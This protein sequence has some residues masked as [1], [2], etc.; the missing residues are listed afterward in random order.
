MVSRGRHKYRA[1]SVFKECSSSV[2]GTSSR[3]SASYLDVDLGG[4]S[5]RV[6]TIEG[7]K[8]AVQTSRGDDATRQIARFA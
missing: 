2:E 1:R 6:T 4:Q 3:K 5:R 8:V 7:K